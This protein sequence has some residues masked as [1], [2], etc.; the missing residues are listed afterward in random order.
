MKKKA[1]IRYAVSFVILIVLLLMLFFWNINAGSV[2]M[3]V[4]E[5]FDI[6]VKKTG[7]QTAYNI[8]WQIRL[9]RILAALLLGG[10]LSVSGFLLQTFFGNPIAG[11]FVLGI[12]SG[13]KLVVSLVMIFLLSRGIASSSLVMILAAFVG[14]MISMGFILLVSRKVKRMSMLVICGV[15]IGYICSAVTDFVVT[16]ADDSNI[17][18]LHNWS[19]GSFSGTTWGNVQVCTVVVLISL[20]LAFLMSKPM[21]A[22]Q[23]GENYAQNMGVNIKAFRISLILLSSVLS[24]TVTAFAGPISFVGIAVPHLIKSLMKT[25][26]PILIIPGC[27]LGG[28][29]FCL[30]CDLIARTVFAPTE[31]SISSVTAIFGAPVVIY[32]M[33]RKQR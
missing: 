30:F 8:V 13:A 26:K 14:S 33:V 7:E 25:A 4:K 17:V 27:F 1:Q 2:Q 11:P 10:A 24:A 22:Y 5:I 9:P 32:M 6:I 15:M 31:L 20:A 28:A 29:V 18:N 21:S 19:L 16:F 23:L 12:S 3:S